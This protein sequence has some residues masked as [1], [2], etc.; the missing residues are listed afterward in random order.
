MILRV[1]GLG[2]AVYGAVMLAL[3]YIPSTKQWALTHSI[4]AVVSRTDRRVGNTVEGAVDM[5]M[6]LA[7]S[8]VL[9]FAGLWIGLLVP[10]LLNRNRRRMMREAGYED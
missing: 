5:P 10:A 3:L 8:A 2:M 4:A 6:A 1:L 7:G 9:I